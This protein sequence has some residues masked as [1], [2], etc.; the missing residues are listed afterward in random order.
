MYQAS[1]LVKAMAL[2]QKFVGGAPYF[3][4]HSIE[5]VSVYRDLVVRESDMLP[6]YLAVRFKLRL[7]FLVGVWS[8]EK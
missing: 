7:P 2:S 1:G 4:V 8:I 5:L 3:S 6:V